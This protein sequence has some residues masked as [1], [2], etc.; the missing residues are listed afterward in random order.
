VIVAFYYLFG[1]R[2]IGK[3]VSILGTVNLTSIPQLSFENYLR[4]LLASL[5]QLLL[6]FLLFGIYHQINVFQ[7]SFS[8]TQCFQVILLGVV[9]G[10]SQLGAATGLSLFC[11]EIVS[12]LSGRRILLGGDIQLFASTGWMGQFTAVFRHNWIAGTLVSA[13]YIAGEELVFRKLLLTGL[14]EN[15]YVLGILVSTTLFAV[16]QV[17]GIENS[18]F[19]IFPVSGALVVGITN[20]LLFIHGGSIVICIIS[21]LIFFLGGIYGVIKEGGRGYDLF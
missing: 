16:V 6:F 17:V 12:S 21:H 3:V 1:R 8:F 9:L 10:F 7:A 2:W 5:A 15:F 13:M 14:S 20:G 11:I 4:I 19:W 18:M